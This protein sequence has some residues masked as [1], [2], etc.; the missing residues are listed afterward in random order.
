[1]NRLGLR[2]EAERHAAFGSR[3]RCESGVAA[4][5]CHRSPKPWRRKIRLPAVPVGAITL[6]MKGRG[7]PRLLGD[8]RQNGPGKRHNEPIGSGL[9]NADVCRNTNRATVST[10]PLS[11][12]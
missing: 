10:D 6:L 4:A 5:L 7:Q 2:R 12:T 11:L 8:M 3:F 9:R 1:M